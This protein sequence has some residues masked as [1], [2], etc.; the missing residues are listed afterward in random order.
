MGRSTPTSTTTN[1]PGPFLGDERAAYLALTSVPGVGQV[2]LKSLLEACGGALGVMY[3]PRELLRA[4]PGVPQPTADLIAR[5]SV[6][7]GW[8]LEQRIAALGAALLV[9][10][11]PEYPSILDDI[12]TPPPF[13]VAK[14]AL[15]LLSRQAVA[16]V[17]S[18][19]HSRYGAEVCRTIARAA[20]SAG[21]TVVSGMARGID[22]ISH[23][24]VLDAGGTSIGVLGTGIDVAYPSS[25]QRLY[26]R[27][28]HE[29]NGL[30]LTEFPPG[31][32]PTRGSFPRRNRLISGLAPVT[33]VV[34]AAAASGALGTAAHALL[35]GREVLAVPGPITSATSVGTNR[36]L[37][38]GATP[39]LGLDDLLVHYPGGG[40]SERSSPGGSTNDNPQARV[41]AMLG[42]GA[43]HADEIARCL[44][45]PAGEVLGL[46]SVMELTGVVRQEPGLMFGPT[47]S[48]L[49]PQ[50]G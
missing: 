11:D 20:A 2:H 26:R 38:E 18:R 13:L 25:N 27:M 5:S 33:V 1:P 23:E 43:V 10:G 6:E 15:D 30:L 45:L 42:N 21:L 19:T 46:L 37:R 16:V 12:P 8:V 17:G 4:V 36:L 35:Q 28:L 39:L 34:E 9:P 44:D 31:T 50:S 3:A 24:A 49:S 14:G 29:E 7:A 40:V 41:M 47:V 48:I 22:A 32:R